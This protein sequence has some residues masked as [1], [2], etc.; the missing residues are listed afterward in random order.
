MKMLFA[1]L[2]GYALLSLPDYAAAQSLATHRSAINDLFVTADSDPPV[3]DR[4]APAGDKGDKPG[5]LNKATLKTCCQKIVKDIQRVYFLHN[6]NGKM[7]LQVRGLYTRGTALFFSLRLTNRSLLAYDV[8]SIGFFIM[9]KG[10]HKQLP[11]R[12]NQLSPVYVY[13]SVARVK[14]FGR[15]TSVM[16]LPRL[17]LARGQRLLIEVSEKNG[18]RQLQV[19][20][21]PFI[22][23]NARLI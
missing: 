15:V 23:E 21:S 7:K 10:Q 12:L 16:V 20:A 2:T 19:L 1:F 14:G 13:D 8:D 17:K 4:T 9:Q 5:E 22:L 6:R 18:G 11:V 3:P